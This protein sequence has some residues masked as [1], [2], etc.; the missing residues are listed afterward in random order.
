[1]WEPAGKTWDLFSECLL[2]MCYWMSWSV[3][4]L[5][6]KYKTAYLEGIMQD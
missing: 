6:Q 2:A 1:M 4:P 3:F 5:K